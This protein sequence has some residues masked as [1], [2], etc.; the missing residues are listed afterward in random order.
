MK[1][2]C[3]S[4]RSSFEITERNFDFYAG[5]T[6]TV[7]EKRFAI[8]EPT[9]CPICRWQRRLAFRNERQLYQ[10]NSDLSDKQI[11]SVFSP[12]SGY[13]VYDQDEWFSDAWDGC[14]FS[15]PF[16][17]SRSFTE[18]FSDLIRAVPHAAL[19]TTNTEN[20]HFTNYALNLK[21]CY[22]VFGATDDEN[23]LYGNFIISCRDCLDCIS[24]VDSELCYEGITSVACYNCS[25][26]MNCRNC[27]D[28]LFIEDCESCQS[29][30]LC[31]GLYKK[32]FHVLNQP[33]G[34]QRFEEIRQTLFPLTR[35]KI[36]ELY[37]QLTELKQDLPHRGAHIYASEN[38]SGDMVFN[39]KNCAFCFDATDC[40]EGM[41][42][43]N[44]KKCFMAQD[45]SY[46][47]PLG[48]Q[49]GYEACSS[50]GSQLMGTFLC[51]YCDYTYY[52]MECRS[53][54]HLFGCMGLR[55]KEYCVFNQQLSRKEYEELVPR[56][57][58][59]MQQRGEWGEYL[60]PKL[61]FFGYNETVAQEN[62]PL[63][64]DK[65]RSAGWN[66]RDTVP[67]AP[68]GTPRQDIPEDIRSVDR[69]FAGSVLSCQRSGRSFKI[70]SAELDFY[71]KQDLPLPHLCPD[72]RH[73]DRLARRLPRRGW[74][75]KCASTG[76]ETFSP[77]TEKSV[78]TVISND[79]YLKIV[80]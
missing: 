50:L 34:K 44:S 6:P 40:E 16:D 53:S 75:R 70:N 8:P 66:W 24:M 65:A 7:G 36:Q 79:E 23:C 39:S 61:S 10:R 22:L 48:I 78:K 15:R 56:I 59:S 43:H 58:A 25:F 3:Q 26:F 57:I 71:L 60:N 74:W 27:T 69:A 18:Q 68:Q 80:R 42:L 52:S 64:R 13:K 35:S 62:L 63:V 37:S 55:N 46:N 33:V 32:E 2:E 31:F 20:S 11:I 67:P 38:C 47:A 73:F 17:F 1:R 12:D 51:W 19:Y 29:C 41:Y 28:S 45:C 21:N 30:L 5:I 76:E 14:E 72:E 54:K 49:F 9:R 4:C 77:Y